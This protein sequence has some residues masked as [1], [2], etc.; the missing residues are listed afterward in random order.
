MNRSIKIKNN[1]CI[2]KINVN[3]E[4]N[5]LKNQTDIYVSDIDSNELSVSEETSIYRQHWRWILYIENSREGLP[6]IK[7]MVKS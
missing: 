5:N 6:H 3:M 7:N 4:E 1:M 2:S